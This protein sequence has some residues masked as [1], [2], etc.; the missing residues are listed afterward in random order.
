VSI[1]D[2]LR[3]P[4]IEAAYSRRQEHRIR[5]IAPG[6]IANFTVLDDDPYA[7]ETIKLKD[8]G[9]WRAVLEGALRPVGRVENGRI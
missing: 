3:A 9:V 2:A 5:A 4:T 8:I 1:D 6:K 7:V